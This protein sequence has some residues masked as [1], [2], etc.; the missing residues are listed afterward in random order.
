MSY[1][2]RY[3]QR[4][5]VDQTSRTRSP[6]AGV[7]LINRVP[8]PSASRGGLPVRGGWS[9]SSAPKQGDG[10]LHNNVRL[11]TTPAARGGISQRLSAGG[12]RPGA[13]SNTLND[14]GLASAV[15]QKL[16]GFQEL[17]HLMQ[18]LAD[19][20]KKEES[21][22]QN[23]M[24][25]LLVV[26]TSST[27]LHGSPQP[28]RKHP[29]SVD[30]NCNLKQQEQSQ[31][32]ELQIAVEERDKAIAMLRLFREEGNTVMQRMHQS[33]RHAHEQHES[34]MLKVE[35]LTVENARMRYIVR[36]VK[37]FSEDLKDSEEEQHSSDDGGVRD[38]GSPTTTTAT[39]DVVGSD[40]NKHSSTQ[41]HVHRMMLAKETISKLDDLLQEADAV[42]T[43][44]R[45]QNEELLRQNEAMR[46]R[47]RR[48]AALNQQ[49][50][51]SNSDDA[52][53]PL[54]DVLNIDV[55]KADDES[56]AA[57]VQRVKQQLRTEKRHRLE[58]EE[59]SHKLLIEHQKNVHL[60]EQRLLQ[61][62]MVGTPR[63]GTPRKA[64]STMASSS[65]SQSQ[66]HHHH[67]QRLSGGAA[68]FE[69]QLSQ[70]SSL[71]GSSTVSQPPHH[72][73]IESATSPT[74]LD[75]ET[76]L[77]LRGS[78]MPSPSLQHQGDS[79]DDML[80]DCK[81]SPDAVPPARDGSAGVDE[82]GDPMLELQS[83]EAQLNEVVASLEEA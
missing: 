61:R 41:H 39:V 10:S 59:L 45:T 79:P 7:R 83:I 34:L 62:N 65:V 52:S 30:E 67:H 80:V 66:H 11:S 82:L 69:P 17:R 54:S 72:G 22:L 40:H 36:E 73:R 60:L 63:S 13:S 46:Q 57:Y 12:G 56:L 28:S 70:T 9:L 74:N 76:A 1:A 33:L 71:V 49:P 31:G 5:V 75:E 19:R 32:H 4:G 29:G 53:E 35:K 20:H 78:P 2:S 55:S 15:S 68:T 42:I 8:S 38:G 16:R 81:R 64:R 27:P 18:S 24:K 44:L 21:E 26:R 77:L 25:R 3:S 48:E 58:A 50:A 47:E 51:A 37:Y 23:L 43:S 6:G 14:P